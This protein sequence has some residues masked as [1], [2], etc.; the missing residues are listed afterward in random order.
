MTEDQLKILESLEQYPLNNY[1]GLHIG[2]DDPKNLQPDHWICHY[3]K[4]SLSGY[5]SL[6]KL[7]AD[8]AD[9]CVKAGYAKAPENALLN[10]KSK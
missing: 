10:P 5:Y 8:L 1:G 6:P 3:G 7:L 2:K 9:E 4:I